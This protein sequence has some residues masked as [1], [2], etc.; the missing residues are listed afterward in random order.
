MKNDL[1]TR[2]PLITLPLNRGRVHTI[3]ARAVNVYAEKDDI[4]N[5]WRVAKRPGFRNYSGLPNWGGP[6]GGGITHWENSIYGVS[7]TASAGNYLLYKGNTS[8]GAVDHTKTRYWFQGIPS[9]TPT[10]FFGN[11]A[12]YY[13][14]D[15]TSITAIADATFTAFMANLAGGIVFLNGR[16]Y[17]MTVDGEIYG[18]TN[19]NDATAWDATNVIVADQ[20]SGTGQLIALHMNYILAIKDTITEVFQDEGNP[21][22]GS[23]LGKVQGG[24]IPYGTV[25]PETFA[26]SEDNSFWVGSGIAAGGEQAGKQVIRLRGLEPQV[27]STPEIERLVDYWP[28]VYGSIITFAGHRFYCLSTLSDVPDLLFD[29][30][31]EIWLQMYIGHDG[32]K[33]T[34]RGSAPF[35]LTGQLCMTFHGVPF[36]FDPTATTDGTLNFDDHLPIVIDIYTPNLDFGV[37]I[38]KQ[39]NALYFTGDQ[40]EGCVIQ[41]RYS[42][43]DYQTWTDFQTLD[44]SVDKPYLTDQGQFSKRAYHIRHKGST[45]LRL[46]AMGLRMDLCVL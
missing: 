10:L 9:A 42:D 6:V 8:L 37:D 3:D 11:K 32:T 36:S 7:G 26:S 28:Y 40:E 17:V 25:R 39:L 29:I 27:I 15:G 20:S 14:T 4:L 2:W 46:R 23:P 30:E 35:G 34:I 44:L 12:V 22:P 45:G 21:A 18:A 13:T 33:A 38:N 19:L 43:D 41:V 24:R 16:A 1:P 31:E 5:E